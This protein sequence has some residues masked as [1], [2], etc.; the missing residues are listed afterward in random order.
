MDLLSILLLL[1]VAAAVILALRHM[2]KHKSTCGGNCAGCGMD[3]EKR[4]K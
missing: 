3:C 4:S 2:K 1:L